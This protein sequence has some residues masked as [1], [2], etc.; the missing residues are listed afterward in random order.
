MPSSAHGDAL[1]LRQVLTH[2]VANAIK[3][4][5]RGEVTVGMELESSDDSGVVLHGWVRD[6]G[7]G[8][9]QEQLARMFQP[10]M[11]ADSSTTRRFGGTGLGLVICRQLVERMGGRLWAESS[12]GQGST[13]HFTIPVRVEATSTV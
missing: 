6:T 1:R 12:P 9:T 3:F 11:Q 13:F 4:T 7:L 10:F 2:L 5:D 8:I